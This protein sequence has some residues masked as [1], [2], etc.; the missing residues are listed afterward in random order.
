MLTSNQVFAPVS[1]LWCN[2]RVRLNQSNVC[3]NIQYVTVDFGVFPYNTRHHSNE[4]ENI[5]MLIRKTIL[6]ALLFVLHTVVLAG[7]L[8]IATGRE[9]GT[10][11]RFGEDMKRIAATENV[12]LRV[13]PSKGSVQNLVALYERNNLHLAISQVD[14]LFFMER[15]GNTDEKKLVSAIRVV[16]PLYTEE[17][18]LVARKGIG[19]FSDLTGKHV[20]V[21]EEGS[22]TAIT[23]Q[24]LFAL[25]NVEPAQMAWLEAD[26]AVEAL[27]NGKIDAV[28]IVAGSPMKLLQQKLLADADIGLIS[29]EEEAFQELY[30]PPV[31]IP[32]GTYEWQ[33]SEVRTLG[34]MS[35][36]VTL[37]LAADSKA[38]EEIRRLSGVVTRDIAWLISNGHEKWA[39]VNFDYSVD[40]PN[41]SLCSN[42]FR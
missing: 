25:T 40:E 9:T 18:H 12:D 37:N 13:Y 27:L 42:L 17:V 19:R 23:A 41:R 5:V 8:G 15:L 26:Q 32:A 22:G 20:A 33:D 1:P 29:L 3:A 30:G 4:C 21:G 39:Q 16:L 2:I 31:R 11:Y 35:L 34:I 14:V 38:C 10:Y 7:T 36:L 28:I 24:T 6:S